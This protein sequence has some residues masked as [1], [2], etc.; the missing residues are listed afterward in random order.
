[1]KLTLTEEQTKHWEEWVKGKVR[2][3]VEEMTAIR[4]AIDMSNPKDMQEGLQKIKDRMNLLYEE[5]AKEAAELVVK[6]AIIEP[7]KELFKDMVNAPDSRP[8]LPE[9]RE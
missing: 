2:A 4:D 1:M 6:Q 7:L 3:C 8:D 9:V 5:I